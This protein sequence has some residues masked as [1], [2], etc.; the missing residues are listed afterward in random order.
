MDYVKLCILW[1]KGCDLDS[2]SGGLLEI[3]MYFRVLP[4]QV[5]KHPLDDS[6]VG[7]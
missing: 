5:W 3:C 7:I 1:I 6:E 2:G 4:E